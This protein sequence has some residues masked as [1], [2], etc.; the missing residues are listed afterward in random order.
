MVFIGGNS[1]L[2]RP[3][4]PSVPQDPVI[5]TQVMASNAG[6][7]YNAVSDLTIAQPHPDISDVIN[8]RIVS[9]MSDINKSTAALI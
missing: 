9:I 1:G 3:H 7:N 4:S 8:T 5:D 2:I 6:H